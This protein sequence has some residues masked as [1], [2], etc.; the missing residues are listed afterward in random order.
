MTPRLRMIAIHRAEQEYAEAM[1]VLIQ[2]RLKVKN[3]RTEH[4]KF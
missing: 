3:E 1:L 4:E 2:S